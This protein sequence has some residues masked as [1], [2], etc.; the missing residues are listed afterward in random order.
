MPRR[1]FALAGA[2]AASVAAAV[3][4]AAY[5]PGA[6]GAGD[7]YYPFAGNGGYDVS[8]YDLELDYQPADPDFLRGEAEITARA[9]HSLSRFNLDLR[10]WFTVSRIEVNGSR[11]TFTREGAHELV[12]TP[13]KGIR[14]GKKFEVEVEYA[15]DPQHVVD[16][17]NSIEGW[18]RTHDGAFVVNEPQGSPGWYPANDTPKDKATYDFEVSVPEG[19]EA[20][21]NGVLEGRKTKRGRTTWEWEERDP[22]AP[23]LATA[24]NGDFELRFGRTLGGLLEYNAVDPTTRRSLSPTSP[25][26]PQLAWSLIESTQPAALQLFTDLYGPYPFDAIGAIVDYAPNVFYSLESQGKANYWRVPP[27]STIVHEVAHQWFGN[28]VTPEQWPDIWLNEGFATWSEW[29]YDERNDGP[30][31]QETF[32]DLYEAWGSDPDFDYLN[33]PPGDVGGPEHLFAGTVYDRGAMTL[34]ALRVK[35][36]DEAF[37]R[38]LR[39]WYFKYRYG[40]ATTADFTAVAEGVSGQQLDDFFRVW[41]YESGKPADW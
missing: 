3:P 28:A 18:I 24:T 39:T 29:I 10:P 26:E 5:S 8:H 35:V 16:P 15:G 40:N 31:A 32:G 1:T 2:L 11:A 37:F 6:P 22:M 41:L 12:I 9:T 33:V 20:I 30:T 25:P 7:P 27:E 14:R 17:D 4:A 23:Y 38:T 19:L 13:R 34:Q 21:A 36:G